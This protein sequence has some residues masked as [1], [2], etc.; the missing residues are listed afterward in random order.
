MSWEERRSRFAV[1]KKILAV[2][3][4]L[5]ATLVLLG[6]FLPSRTKRFFLQDL[7]SELSGKG[8]E[9]AQ[10]RFRQRLEILNLDPNVLQLELLVR[11]KERVL[12]VSNGET[13]IASYPV[14]L[15]FSPEGQKETANDGR[16][17]EGSYFICYKKENSRYHLFLGATYPSPDDASRAL[18]KGI[19]CATEAE[20][21]LEAGMKRARPPWNSP[22]GGPFGI[23]GFGT[24]EDWTEGTVAMSNPHVEEIFWNVP[25]GTPLTVIP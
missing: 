22:L 15:G 6:V 7:Q 17:P 19:I 20:A 21:I 16:T 24:G 13:V 3:V 4:G 11:K 9:R 14:A 25:M 12:V 1:G 5:L 8:Q 10:A 18:S 23:H 2:L